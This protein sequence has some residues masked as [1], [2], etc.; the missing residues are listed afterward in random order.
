MRIV[1][2]EDGS[3]ASVFHHLLAAE[4][5]DSRRRLFPMIA[6]EAEAGDHRGGSVC[7]VRG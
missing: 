2:V 3:R 4:G 5:Q 1:V 7:G 6:T